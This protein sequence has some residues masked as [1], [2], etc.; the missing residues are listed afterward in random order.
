[1]KQYVYFHTIEFTGIGLWSDVPVPSRI[2]R[3]RTSYQYLIAFLSTLHSINTSSFLNKSVETFISS[4][5]SVETFTSSNSLS[6]IFLTLFKD[7]EKNEFN[8]SGCGIY[9]LEAQLRLPFF[10]YRQVFTVSF[11]IFYHII[12]QIN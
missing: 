8:S 7:T 6:F 4:N 2:I 11:E 1:M 5:S 12:P 9:F 10:V 3:N